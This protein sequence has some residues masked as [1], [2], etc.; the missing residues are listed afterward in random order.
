MLV[1]PGASAAEGIMP[2]TLGGAMRTS[3]PHAASA[4]TAVTT[5]SPRFTGQ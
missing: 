2:A 1:P 5:T 4:A 3:P